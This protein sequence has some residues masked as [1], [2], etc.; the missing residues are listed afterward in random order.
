MKISFVH[1]A[2]LHLGRQFHFGKRG[3]EL[4]NQKRNDLWTT[5]DKILE[6]CEKNSVDFLLISGDLF[7]TAQV[8]IA[9]VARAADKFR[10][11][12]TTQVVCIAGNHDFY[13]KESIY[14][15]VTWPGN[16]TIMKTGQMESVRFPE[17]ETTIYGL[18]WTKTHYDKIPFQD[19]IDLDDTT[20]NIMMLHGEVYNTTSEYMP[21]NISDYDYFDY[22]ALGHIHKHEM[23]TNRMGYC[24]SPEG[25]D[26]GEMGEHG[27]ILGQ[28]EDHRVSTK[29]LPISLRTYNKVELRIEP[30]MTMDGIKRMALDRIPKEEREKNFYRLVLSGYISKDLD[31]KW[32]KEELEANFYYLE[33]D[34]RRLEV[35]L[36][37]NAILKDNKN[38]MIGAFILEM[39]KHKNNPIAKKA[40]VYGLE[41]IFKD[42]REG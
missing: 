26:F 6:I 14:N 21:L 37:L 19:H 11:L 35:D 38:N 20:N 42:G 34:A 3:K 33:I 22:V 10:G 28:I 32:L 17:L 18:S 4:G 25:L 24:G 15:L 31:L 36:D 29:F 39:K 41:G 13:G 5:F 40:L 23:L 16:V 7:D 12:S 30:E 2:D 1:T 8:D 9:K 27:V